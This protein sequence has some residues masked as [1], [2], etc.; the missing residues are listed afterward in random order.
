MIN[1]IL[2][3]SWTLLAVVFMVACSPMEDDSYSLG[4]LGT[5]SS[6]QISFTQTPSATSA[7]II[8]FTNTTELKGVALLSWN[9]GNGAS[10]KE[11]V[12]VGKFPFAGDYNVSLTVYTADGTAATKSVVVKIAA[13]DYSLIS[14][15]AYV[16]LTGG[17]TD[18]DGKTWVL[19]QYN[20]FAR[21]VANATG[22]K[23]S[24]H[25]GLG[26]QNSY[27]QTWWG[28]GA[29]EKSSWSLYAHKFTFIQNGVQLKIQN[30][31][32]GYGRK[33]SAETKGG[34]TINTVNGDDAEFNYSGGNY[35]FALVEGGKYPVI[36]LSGNAFLGYYCGSQDYE[37]VYQTDK[38]M[39]LRVNNT[40]ESQDWVFVYCLQ[41]LNVA[42][43]AVVKTLKAIPLAEDFETGAS[44]ILWTKEDMG[45]KSAITD[46]PVPL[47]V[48]ES[49][50]V[51]RYQKSTGFYSN[52][53]FTAT[54][55]LFDLSK[56][57]KIRLKVYIPSYNDYT[58]ANNV[59]GSWISN[60]NL[61]PQLSV[62]L[63]NSSLGGNAWQTQ[64]EVVKAN[65]QKDKWLELEFDFSHVADR[66]D[67][68]KIVIQ[69]GAE[70]HAGPG[71]FFFDDFSFSE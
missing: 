58:T 31:G 61:L 64:T 67:Y 70:G 42:P 24:G 43:P 29:N 4:D 62:K 32:V 47:P 21:E 45:S 28:A 50:K 44:S 51:Y 55:Y 34:F 5:I 59:A 63:Q 33:A 23:I 19:D 57:N 36:T 12:I 69:F 6:D 13:N 3:Y 38:V 26:P 66:K 37:I 41:E 27:G 25:L 14:T 52:L 56:Q 15:P 18:A 1:S 60:A 49:E 46:N 48:N 71:L 68:D 17:A 39:A 7:N 35:T 8:T 53:S 11:N 22:L 10:G 40:V 30:E 20:N 16:N 65:L 2:K 9:L 54:T